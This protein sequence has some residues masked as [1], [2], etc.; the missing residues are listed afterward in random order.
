MKMQAFKRN[1]HGEAQTQHKCGA[2]FDNC[3][4][5]VRAYCPAC[6]KCSFCGRKEETWKLDPEHP[7]RYD[8]KDGERQKGRDL[9]IPHYPIVM[10]K[11]EILGKRNT[12]RRKI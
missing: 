10:T 1:K 5:G 8:M 2:L 3:K 4:C 9:Y 7:I 11:P 6:S 12:R